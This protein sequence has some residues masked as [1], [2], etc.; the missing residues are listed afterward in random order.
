MVERRT[1]S[2]EAPDAVRAEPPDGGTAERL[3]YTEVAPGRWQALL[4]QADEGLWRFDDGQATAVAAVGPPSP[5]EY[6][7]PLASAEPLARL[8][9]ATGG[10]QSW[11]ADGIPAVRMVPEGRRMAGRSWVGLAER[12]AHRVTGLRLMPLLPAE[13]AA[14]AVGLLMLAG[15]LREGR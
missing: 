10:H 14:L 2:E 6:K 15:W 7:N 11:L 3:S 1:L 8:V 13:L 9:S 5:A 12:D 4:E